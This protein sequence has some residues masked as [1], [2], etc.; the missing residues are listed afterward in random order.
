VGTKREHPGVYRRETK[1]GTRWVLMYRETPGGPQRKKTFALQRDALDFRRGVES[2]KAKDPQRDPD[3]GKES[4]GA[5]IDRW[6]AMT[7]RS[8]P[9][10]RS[11]TAAAPCTPSGRGMSQ[12]RS[13]LAVCGHSSICRSGGTRRFALPAARTTPKQL[14]ET[15]RC[16]ARRCTRLS[17]TWGPTTAPRTK[18]RPR[19]GISVL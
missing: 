12:S 7:I 11:G 6:R 10:M 3:A 2:A 18:G 15:Q 8:R 19:V 4:L 9:R 5:F 1:A 13:V 17:K 14:P 16:Y